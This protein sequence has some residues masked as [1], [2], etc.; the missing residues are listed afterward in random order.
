MSVTQ[1]LCKANGQR[2]GWRMA[3][4]GPSSPVAD[5][6]G[7]R[8]GRRAQRQPQLCP[9]ALTLDMSSPASPLY[10]WENR[11]SSRRKVSSSPGET[12]AGLGPHP[13]RGDVR[14]RLGPQGHGE[15][16]APVPADRQPRCGVRRGS[17]E[18]A[19]SLED[20][21]GRGARLVEMT[22]RAGGPPG[23]HSLAVKN[24]S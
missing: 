4:G 6:L 21:P 19:L 22:V 17:A 16:P 5:A 12:R 10:R 24:L 2:S 13:G 20:P 9:R 11:G 18:A 3:R 1:P 15:A 14:P 7:T 8:S 23:G